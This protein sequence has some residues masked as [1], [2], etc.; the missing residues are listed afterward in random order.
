[1]TVLI[2]DDSSIVRRVLKGVVQRYFD[3]PLILEAKDGSVAMQAV[4]AYEVDLMLLDWN[5]PVMDGEAVVKAVR[6]EKKHNRMKI[7][8]ATTEGG[9]ASVLK[10]VKQGVNG[11]L[12]KPFQE[13][14][15]VKTLDKVAGRMRAK[16]S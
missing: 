8:M 2:V 13:D 1:M 10:M 3:E 11:Y 15:I 7:V 4:N 12:V 9:K 14:N 5:M 6:A 16:K